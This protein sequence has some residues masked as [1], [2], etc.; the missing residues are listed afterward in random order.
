LGAGDTVGL[1][2]ART[3]SHEARGF[4]Y[5]D[6]GVPL[7]FLAGPSRGGVE[8]GVVVYAS[9]FR[10]GLIVAGMGPASSVPRSVEADA[11]TVTASALSL[12]DVVGEFR[13]CLPLA[14][15]RPWLGARIGA[16]IARGE[17]AVDLECIDLER[18]GFV[19]GPDAGF[20]IRFPKDLALAVDFSRYIGVDESGSAP[21]ISLGWAPSITGGE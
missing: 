18:R 15:F 1:D 9:A 12:V 13:P 5:P 16:A 14:T 11:G 4:S 2:E 20:D 3:V 8:F 6:V 10:A 7:E 17:R 19:A 21:S